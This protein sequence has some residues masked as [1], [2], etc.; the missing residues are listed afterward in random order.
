MLNAILFLNQHGT[1]TYRKT[2]NDSRNKIN[3]K[4]KH[5][6]CYIM[7]SLIYGHN[8]I[9]VSVASRQPA[10]Y[11]RWRRDWLST[12]NRQQLLKVRHQTATNWGVGRERSG[13]GVVKSAFYED[14]YVVAVYV[15]NP[16]RDTF[17]RNSRKRWSSGLTCNGGFL[18]FKTLTF[19]GKKWLL[20][21][22]VDIVF[23]L[24]IAL[25]GRRSKE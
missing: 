24:A 10:I 13:A 8:P 3:A 17:I 14:L 12:G 23:T 6:F 18:R 25:M 21:F 9:D 5:V 4:A 7:R 15:Q 20:I 2:R 1:K 11:F 22:T 19:L 16:R